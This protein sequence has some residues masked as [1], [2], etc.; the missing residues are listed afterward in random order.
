MVT[1]AKLRAAAVEAE[2]FFIL[3][4]PHDTQNRMYFQGVLKRRWTN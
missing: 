3:P 4:Y 2:Q 1:D